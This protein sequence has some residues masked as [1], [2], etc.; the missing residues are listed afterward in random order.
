MRSPEL[1]DPPLSE[2]ERR[3]IFTRAAS[4]ILPYPLAVA[5]APFSADASLAI[6]AA[7]AGFYALPIASGR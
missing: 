3:R 7:V 6:C 2:E 5:L 4:G 1:L